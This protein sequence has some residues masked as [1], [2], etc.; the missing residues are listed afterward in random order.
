MN[1][2]VERSVRIPEPSG[3]ALDG[4]LAVPE[5]RVG[6]VVFAHG[7]GSSRLSRRNRMVAGHLQELGLATLLLDL[8]TGA[9][10]HV[11]QQGGRLR[12]DVDLL[13]ERLAAAADWV[14]MRPDMGSVPLGYFGASTGAAAALIAAARDPEG[15][16]AVVSR[17]GRVDMAG[18]WLPRVK[19]PTLLIVGS[20][21]DIVL[22]LNREAQVRL[23]A[24]SRL[25]IV[26]GASHLFEE[27]GALESVADHAGEWLCRHLGEGAAGTGGAADR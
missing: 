4:D 7:S 14:R 9:E 24:P 23:H 16:A 18:E 6:L 21:D 10:E 22:E 1:T 5:D 17:G 25:V 27:A 12:F 8:L 26:P 20:L 3:R 13:A 11:E 2:L 19:A 15:V